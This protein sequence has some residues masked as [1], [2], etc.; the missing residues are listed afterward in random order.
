MIGNHERVEKHEKIR[1]NYE[2]KIKDRKIKREGFGAGRL[3]FCSFSV[4]SVP[5]VL[6]VVI[7]IPVLKIPLRVAGMDDRTG[8]GWLGRVM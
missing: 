3:R 6:S 5:S 2:R 7:K 1:Q 8:R 4:L